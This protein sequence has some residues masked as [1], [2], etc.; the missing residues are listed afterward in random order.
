MTE[1]HCL[2]L[3]FVWTLFQLV[4]VLCNGISPT[5][6]IKFNTLIK[7]YSKLYGRYK[8]AECAALLALTSPDISST[9]CDFNYVIHNNKFQIFAKTSMEYLSRLKRDCRWNYEEG[10]S[11]LFKIFKV[12]VTFVKSLNDAWMARKDLFI[13][14]ALYYK[15]ADIQMRQYYFGSNQFIGEDLGIATESEFVKLRR[16]VEQKCQIMSGIQI[17]AKTAKE[18]FKKSDGRNAPMS[19]FK[20]AVVQLVSEVEKVEKHRINRLHTQLPL[21]IMNTALYA[22]KPGRDRD[23]GDEI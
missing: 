17:D 14:T 2:I 18:F 8:T 15:N 4:Y 5:E 22:L 7:N 12:F 21:D 23:V 1:K 10:F 19:E 6:R 20:E 16:T 11:E 13:S 9:L 3:T